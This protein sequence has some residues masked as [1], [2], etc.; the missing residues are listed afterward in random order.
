M[1]FSDEFSFSDATLLVILFFQNAVEK[2]FNE[3]KLQDLNSF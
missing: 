2:K 1:D 3:G